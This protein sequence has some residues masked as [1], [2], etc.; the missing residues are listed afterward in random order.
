MNS[1]KNRI[2]PRSGIGVAARAAVSA[3]SM[4]VLL[5]CAAGARAQGEFA[6]PSYSFEGDLQG[7]GPNG[8]GVTVTLDT[9][10]ATDG[11]NSMK[12]S[13]HPL[14]TFVGALTPTLAPQ[15]GDPPGLDFVV[16]D[17]TVTEQVPAEGFVSAGITVFG[18]SQPD[19]PGGQQFG[20]QAQFQFDENLLIGDLAIDTPHEVRIDFTQ[21]THPLTFAAAS[22]EEIF[23]A[24]PNDLIPTGFQIYINKSQQAWTGYIDDVR[25]GVK[26]DADFNVD[27]AVNSADLGI[28]KGAFALDVLGDA[29]GDL[30]TDGYDFLIWQQ[31]LGPSIVAAGVPEPATLWLAGCCVAGAAVRRG[32]AA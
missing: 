14:A 6:Y 12:V 24:G 11:A 1:L 30:D 27:T 32:R 26:F 31:Q 22:F 7:F 18:A 25:L 13:I 4:I 23:G 9:I 29:D 8:G 19:Y 17:L 2:R 10:G 28:W 21:A 5:S 15:V 20:L 16:F 3:A